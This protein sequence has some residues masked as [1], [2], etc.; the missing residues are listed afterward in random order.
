MTINLKYPANLISVTLWDV[1]IKNMN[2]CKN[3]KNIY[4]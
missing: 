1:S 4:S 3:L 2:L